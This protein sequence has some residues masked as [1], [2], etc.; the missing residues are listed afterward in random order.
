MGRFPT[1]MLSDPAEGKRYKISE[2]LNLVKTFIVIY[3]LKED[4]LR[5]KIKQNVDLC[6]F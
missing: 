6:D 5:I 2:K 1:S 3:G 4:I